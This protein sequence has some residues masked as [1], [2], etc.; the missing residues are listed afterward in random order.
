[1]ELFQILMRDALSQ[2][3]T[4]KKGPIIFICLNFSVIWLKI[5][6]FNID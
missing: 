2:C 3:K 6:V 1:M 5:E 4:K